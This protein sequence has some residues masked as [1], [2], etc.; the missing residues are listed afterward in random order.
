MDK[1]PPVEASVKVNSDRERANFCKKIE[2]L[3]RDGGENGGYFVIWMGM[4][5]VKTKIMY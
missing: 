3:R 5:K 4:L 1:S 2:H